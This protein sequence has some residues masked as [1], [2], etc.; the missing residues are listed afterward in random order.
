MSSRYVLPPAFHA[1]CWIFWSM[2]GASWAILSA[3][4]AISRMRYSRLMSRTS[5]LKI[6]NEGPSTA[7]GYEADCI[8]SSSRR[9][10]KSTHSTD[11]SAGLRSPL[12][13][14]SMTGSMNPS[15]TMSMSSHI[16]TG[17]WSA[18]PSTSSSS[19]RSYRRRKEHD[20]TLLLLS[21]FMAV[22]L[23]VMLPGTYSPVMSCQAL[24]RN[25]S[26]RLISPSSPS[27]RLP[28]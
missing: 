19:L 25:I 18:C 2:S 17:I 1:T 16:L 24:S 8:T 7:A 4:P 9:T 15:K 23:M 14:V 20:D 22:S 12:H 21:E 10:E 26:K 11:I 28:R 27:S 13:D 5:L 6:Q 3:R